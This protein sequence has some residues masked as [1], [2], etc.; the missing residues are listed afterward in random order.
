MRILF[1]HA[2]FPAQFR[3]LAPAL[4]ADPANEVVFATT[5]PRGQL[6]NVRKVYLQA[7]RWQRDGVHRYLR[8]FERAVVNGQTAFR[9]AL[10]LRSEGFV[11]D[12]IY[13]FSGWGHTLYLKDAFPEAKLVC[14]YDWYYRPR[15]SNGDFFPDRP[16]TPDRACL[17][18]VRNAPALLDLASSDWGVV[19]TEWQL[20]QFPRDAL[21][22]LSLLHDGID[23]GWFTPQPGAR[24]SHVGLPADA[25]LITYA[26]R[27]MEPYR[28]FDT[29]LRALELVLRKRPR[30]HAVIAGEDRIV[31]G[32]PPP[33]GAS[34]KTHLLDQLDLPADRVHFTG[35]LAR[36]DMRQLLRSSHAHVYFSA[37]FIPSWSMFEAMACGALLVG[38]DTA[39]V[40]ELVVD[41]V[42]GLLSPFFDHEG[43]AHRLDEA[44]ANQERFAPLR[45]AA[46]RTIVERY[47]LA[48]LLPRQLRMLDQV[49]AGA[50]PLAIEGSVAGRLTGAM[51]G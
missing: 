20:S 48:D 40:T 17:F 27:G 12:L 41:G 18:R 28:G 22:G 31:Y 39:P 44:L 4:A 46:E 3:D 19:T 43:L 1:V 47:A 5:E 7:P 16:M 32:S 11:P 30:A 8:E 6:D 29:F 2:N 38:S 45:A 9:L 42:N 25:E 49:L 34:W 33:G 13:G 35:P 26:T 51:A 37:P 50:E 14:Y 10:Q 15:G 23:T 36:E 21:G 24:F